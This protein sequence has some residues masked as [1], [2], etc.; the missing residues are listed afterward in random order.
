MCFDTKDLRHHVALPLQN[1]PQF[2]NDKTEYY[3]T[4]IFDL[5]T[6]SFSFSLTYRY[7]HLFYLYYV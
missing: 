2:V 3:E 6:Q 4:R 1:C 7:E 5:F